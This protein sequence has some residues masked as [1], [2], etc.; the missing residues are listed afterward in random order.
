VVG[1]PHQKFGGSQSSFL[2]RTECKIFPQ[3]NTKQYLYLGANGA[4]K[5]STLLNPLPVCN[6]IFCSHA[7]V[8]I[9]FLSYCFGVTKNF[10]SCC[11]LGLGQE[12]QLF[13]QFLPVLSRQW[14]YSLLAT[15]FLVQ[16]RQNLEGVTRKQQLS[17]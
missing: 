6:I 14:F 5:E 12:L 10:D 2:N 9:V 11:T 17:E 7:L 3:H 1:L 4:W 16:S 8:Q 13:E 15:V